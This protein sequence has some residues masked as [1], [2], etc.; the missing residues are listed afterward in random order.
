MPD[1]GNQETLGLKVTADTSAYDSAFRASEA[2][3]GELGKAAGRTQDLFDKMLQKWAE[4][5]KAVGNLFG[6]ATASAGGL[7]KALDDAG[8]AQASFF[9]KVGKGWGEFATGMNQGIEL[10]GKLGDALQKVGEM[11]HLAAEMQNLADHVPVERLGAMQDATEGAV[12]KV[13]LMKFSMKALGGEMHLT[14]AGM[15]QLLTAANTLG[16]K[17]F[18]DTMQNAEA[19]LDALRKGSSRE[20]KQFGIA[21]DDTNSKVKNSAQIFEKI[22]AL[23]TEE[24]EVNPQLKALERLQTA[25]HDSLVAIQE[26]V[27]KLLLWLGSLFAGDSEEDPV[28]ANMV[29]AIR[30]AS[31]GNVREEQRQADIEAWGQLNRRSADLV[32]NALV[33]SRTRHGH[34]AGWVP[35]S[36]RGDATGFDF[37]QGAPL[38][39]GQPGSFYGG[40][41]GFVGQVDDV[42]QQ[43]VEKAAAVVKKKWD[44]FDQFRHDLEMRALTG[45]LTLGHSPLVESLRSGDFQLQGGAQG[46][47]F[48]GPSGGGPLDLQLG[49]GNISPG[50]GIGSLGVGYSTPDY[51][52]VPGVA[53][54]FFGGAAEG[55]RIG[56]LKA[57]LEDNTSAIGASLAALTA[58]MEASVEAAIQG[59]ANI[60][61]AFAKGGAEVLKGISI[62]ATGM[63]I[64]ASAEAL[65]GL[66]PQAGAAA[67]AY[68][69]AAAVTGA[70]A[71][72]LGAA[73]GAWSGGKA[74]GPSSSP[75]GGVSPT[76]SRA[77]D[78]GPV[79]VNVYIQG[80]L[81]AADRAKLGE[82]VEEA[83]A[84]GRA[85]GRVRSPSTVT[86]HF[87]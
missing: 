49:Q 8:S 25:W 78:S 40:D 46:V 43:R 27:G 29:A 17:G 54:D 63:A 13:T 10:V 73:G 48:G 22:R 28:K 33:R 79:T 80:M 6:S 2:R 75:G 76:S 51:G 67:A 26:D 34:P 7:K 77:V 84:A 65:F 14:E 32:N 9:S 70:G 41:E 42:T 53:Q 18:G 74:A 19:L 81:A 11:A 3:A 83:A 44:W 56:Q 50:L 38:V 72:L 60:A 82:T 45:Q 86:M 62:R 61:K 85:S 52:N 36:I 47:F 64:F 69:T 1:G 68:W 66:N 5:S 39:P 24:V 87:E 30:R 12:D 4:S 20:L 15:Q 21:I 58:G 37:G 23:A 16:D 55:G 59:N 31:F 57:E 35:P 71:A